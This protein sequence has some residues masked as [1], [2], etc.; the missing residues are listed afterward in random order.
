MV[1]TKR[2]PCKLQL[3]EHNDIIHDLAKCFIYIY[4]KKK[5]RFIKL[6]QIY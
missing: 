6:K 4:I 1:T 3:R 5:K 2:L